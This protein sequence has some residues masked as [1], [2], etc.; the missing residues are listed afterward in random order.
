MAK[1]PLFCVIDIT[2]GDVEF[3]EISTTKKTKNSVHKLKR[4]KKIL[5]TL[6]VES[7]HLL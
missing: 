2:D 1:S 6:G 7:L 3:K 4:N 5:Q